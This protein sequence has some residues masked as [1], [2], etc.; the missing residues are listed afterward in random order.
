MQKVACDT[1]KDTGRA[2]THHSGRPDTSP[3]W[4]VGCEPKPPAPLGSVTSSPAREA[5]IDQ[6]GLLGGVAIHLHRE[7]DTYRADA[8]IRGAHVVARHPT[9][10]G[11]L[12]L[13]A[14]SLGGR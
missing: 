4:R 2:P 14:E 6:G 11:A 8:V 1:C 3:C 10:T 13:V 5:E 9:A 7:G 12:A